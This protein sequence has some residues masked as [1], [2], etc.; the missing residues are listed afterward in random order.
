MRSESDGH[1]FPTD[2]PGFALLDAL[3][4]RSLGPLVRSAVNRY[5]PA[6]QDVQEH[7]HALAAH[8]G[9]AT[10]LRR[11]RVSTLRQE[12]APVPHFVLLDD[13]GDEVARAR[14]A[15]LALGHGPLRWPDSLADAATRGP[16]GDRVMH[17]YQP[18]SY[19]RHEYVIV[20][21]GMA[22][23][24]EWINVLRAGGSVVA[25]RRRTEVVHLP[26]SA[27][28]CYFSS[29]WLDRYHTLDRPARAAILRDLARGTYPIRRSWEAEVGGAT[30]AGRYQPLVGDLL[31][32]EEEGDGL[33]VRIKSESGERVVRADRMIGATGFMPGW[34]AH[35]ILR[36]MVEAG[37]LEVD[38]SIPIL[39][40]D[41]SIPALTNAGRTVAI[42]GSLAGWAFPAADSF[43][44]MKYAARRFA[45]R[46]L[47]RSVGGPARTVTWARMVIGR[48]PGPLP[49]SEIC[50]SP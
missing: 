35:E 13:V 18:K 7:G 22:A 19:G 40:D 26:L 41:C 27:P 39:D 29:P 17:A 38:A 14:H 31:S 10:S 49:A 5:H 12:N 2:Y 21:S 50:V 1:F 4:S 11:R 24:T 8:F 36:R 9:L 23:A 44:G 33:A 32:V 16:L 34:Q 47:G 46:P 43:A 20:G 6:C 45:L 37:A 30:S 25:L 3:R 42:A 48:S 15:L 28:R